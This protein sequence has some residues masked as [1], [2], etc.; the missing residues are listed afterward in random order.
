MVLYN[1]RK[2]ILH[3]KKEKNSDYYF[4]TAHDPCEMNHTQWARNCTTKHVDHLEE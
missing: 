3:Y 1:E 2:H 4:L